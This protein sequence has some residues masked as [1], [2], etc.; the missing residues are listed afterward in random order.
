M[1]IQQAEQWGKVGLRLQTSAAGTDQARRTIRGLGQQTGAAGGTGQDQGCRGRLQA[2][3]LRRRW[4]ENAG[5]ISG[6]SQPSVRSEP[7]PSDRGFPGAA[8]RQ[9]WR[10]LCVDPASRPWPGRVAGRAQPSSARWRDAATARGE[11][12][13]PDRGVVGRNRSIATHHPACG[14][15]DHRNGGRPWNPCFRSTLQRCADPNCPE[16]TEQQAG[17]DRGGGFRLGWAGRGC[18]VAPQASSTRLMAITAM[19]AIRLM[20]ARCCSP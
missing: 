10:T 4:Q 16:R 17:P 2:G 9:A 14:S 11:E 20:M 7:E 13:L 5:A 6:R 12:H 8:Q 3:R 19:P 15:G 18:P 1:P